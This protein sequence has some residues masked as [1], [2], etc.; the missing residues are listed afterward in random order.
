MLEYYI[1]FALIG[2]VAGFLASR[3]M[4]GSKLGLVG[5]L[6]VGVIGALL[7]GWLFGIAGIAVGNIPM[8]IVASTLGAML[9]LWLLR[10]LRI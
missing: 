2:L 6:V 7:G 5:Y 10:V 1:I 9:L 4:G 3:F 8:Q